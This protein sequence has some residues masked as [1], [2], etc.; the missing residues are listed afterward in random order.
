[1]NAQVDIWS[2]IDEILIKYEPVVGLSYIA[3]RAYNH[4]FRQVASLFKLTSDE[5]EKQLSEIDSKVKNKV[6][7]MG[8]DPNMISNM[9]NITST[10][11]FIEIPLKEEEDE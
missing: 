3:T 9:H 2:I 6:I 7:S 4:G 1:M 10:T 5:L 11:D 8:G